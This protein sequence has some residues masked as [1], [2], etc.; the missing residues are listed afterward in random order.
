MT[1]PARLAW[2][3]LAATL[4]LLA[5]Q[6]YLVIASHTPLRS[7]NTDLNTFPIITLGTGLGALVGALVASRHPG[8][9]VGW[10]FCVG[11]LGTAL[12]LAADAFG[13]AVQFHGQ[14]APTWTLEPA[15]VLSY[16][17]G[18]VW[19][20]T[21][22][23]ATFLVV[24]DGRLPSRRW[25]PV[26]WALPVPFAISTIV[27][28]TYASMHHLE[29]HQDESKVASGYVLLLAASW[30]LLALTFVATT[31]SLVLRLRRSDGVLRQQLRWMA[32]A[33]TALLIGTLL[34]ISKPIAGNQPW[35]W[36]LD[37]PLHVGY[38]SVPVA[39][40]VAVLRYR[41]YDIDVVISR[42]A[43]LALLL[44]FVTTCYVVAVVSIGGLLGHRVSE[45][46]TASLLVTA[47]VAL[48]F[49]P[50]RLWAG[51]LADR[52][53]YGRRAAPYIALAELSRRLGESPDP[54]ALL[55]TVAE[56]AAHAVGASRA[57][58]V[59][60]VDTGPNR[61]AAWPAADPA[62]GLTPAPGSTSSVEVPI[63]AQGERLGT[64]AVEMPAGRA[65]RGGDT[66]L[67]LDL[68]NQS[69]IA[70]RNA[71]LSAELAGRV[72]QLRLGTV[73]LVESRRRL[74]TAG[75]AER[76]RL[77]GAIARDVVPHLEPLPGALARL[78]C[79]WQQ[80]DAVRLEPLV[81][82][83]AAALEALREITRGVFP[84]QL[85]RAGLGAALASY[86]GRAGS[87]G[88]VAVDPTAVAR[89]FDPRVEAAA[90]FCVAEAVQSLQSPIEVDVAAPDAQLVLQVR[91]RPNGA[92]AMTQIR[93]R[94]EA[95]GGTV[96]HEMRD[97]RTL[98]DVR[99]PATAA[100]SVTTTP[101]GVSS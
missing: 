101:V 58:A 23:S 46:F 84:A 17:M 8:N 27:L 64:I 54:A 22:V 53:A 9:R 67:L 92:L 83:S 24:P 95:A 50:L 71:R 4:V 56:A 33:A 55:P 89:R 52:A 42:A 35:A 16:S 5:A 37:V 15:V 97:D 65:L 80:D 10:L 96:R 81:A 60:H 85:V 32:A 38:V 99:L 68:A 62:A 34:E 39:A 59:L 69:A 20:L 47:V 45:S 77:E 82:A 70:F 72:E 73:E 44:T 86:L 29:E 74:I 57:R 41:L 26:A 78:A 90:Y 88:H 14:P 11:Q 98:I 66:A 18:A 48:A 31:T 21:V 19:A 43:L 51:R 40:G 25:R 12:G 94:I 6:S 30:V 63:T 28:V 1:R 36:L 76:R 93:D 61:S 75:D 49:Q 13:A 87:L 7:D 3:I 79:D 91:G 2:S 100:G